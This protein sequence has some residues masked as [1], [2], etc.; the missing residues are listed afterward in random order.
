MVR[1]FFVVQDRQTNVCLHENSV[2]SID[3]PVMRIC[4]FG[5][6]INIVAMSVILD[7]HKSECRLFITDGDGLMSS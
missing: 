4:E 7:T 6:D 1:P 5:D 3:L 2:M